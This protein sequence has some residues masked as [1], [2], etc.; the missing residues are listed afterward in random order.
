MRD[1]A[2]K[3]GRAQNDGA[4]MDG[5]Q[6]DGALRNA[7]AWQLRVENQALPVTFKA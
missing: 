3:T 6:M 4:Q 1:A 7:R 2:L 5:A